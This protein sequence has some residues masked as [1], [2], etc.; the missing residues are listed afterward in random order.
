[1]V[2]KSQYQLFSFPYKAMKCSTKVEKQLSPNTF[3]DK[4]K[5]ALAQDI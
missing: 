2:F 1:M 3:A 4:I 5:V